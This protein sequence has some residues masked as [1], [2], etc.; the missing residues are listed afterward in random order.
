MLKKCHCNYWLIELLIERRER[1]G[2]GEKKEA[3]LGVTGQ[4]GVSPPWEAATSLLAT[5]WGGHK[6]V[7]K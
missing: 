4:E 5:T 3:E 6:W 1:Q 2:S 7:L